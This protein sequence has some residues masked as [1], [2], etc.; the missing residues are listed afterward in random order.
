M[1]LRAAA[2][3]CSSAYAVW[4]SW[5]LANR[6]LQHVGSAGPEHV[7]GEV[8]V[9]AADVDDVVG[10]AVGWGC[11]D[12]Q[13]TVGERAAVGVVGIGAVGLGQSDQACGLGHDRR[14]REIDQRVLGPGSGAL[15]RVSLAVVDRIVEP[16]RQPDSHP[17]ESGAVVGQ[18]I[19]PG[20]H[21]GQVPGVVVAPGRVG[22]GGDQRVPD[23]MPS[24]QGP[25]RGEGVGH[26]LG[27]R[28]RSVHVDH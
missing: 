11:Q 19:E 8:G 22:V 28:R 9:L 20:Q 26:W 2:S 15:L 17:V 14:L 6:S 4:N 12:R 27:I 21:L 24:G 3:Q 18:L 13:V 7:V 16:R 23:S 5:G 10:V 25:G 1:L